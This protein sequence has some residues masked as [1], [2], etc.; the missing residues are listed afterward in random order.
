MMIAAGIDLGGTKAEMQI[1]NAD[2]APIASRRDA[3]PDDY[4]ALVAMLTTQIAWA[5]AQAGSDLPIGIGAA[6]LVNPA[7]GL[8]LA[9]NL[10]ASGYPLP[11]DIAKAACTHITYI[12]DCKALALSEAVFGA[13]CGQR[14]VLSITLGTGIGGAIAVDGALLL[15]PTQMGGEVGHTAA[16]AHLV[17]EH[18]LP[19]VLCGCGRVG[20]AET[21][22][23]GPGLTRLAVALTG[24][25]LTAPDIAAR[26]HFDMQPV[27]SVWCDLVADLLRNLTLTIDPDIIVLG[28]GL[29]QI[30]GVADDLSDALTRAQLADFATP[31][32][33]IATGGETSGAR[34]AA[35]AAWQD[36]QRD[37]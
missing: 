36:E 5:Q 8:V 14:T 27:W 9:A 29:S 22:I 23:A 3:T 10:C 16:P 15:G 1:F 24:Q 17:L 21:L 25:S 34:G 20:C 11:A 18:R 30:A 12:N 4:S 32:I 6:G 33:V 26:R 28:G 2:W 37:G 13:G 35:Y 19:L 7:T 31:P